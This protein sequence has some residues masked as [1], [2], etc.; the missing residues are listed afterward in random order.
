VIDEIN[1]HRALRRVTRPMHNFLPF[2]SARNLLVGIDLMHM[3]RKGRLMREGP[4]AISLADQF[5][6]S[7]EDI[8]AA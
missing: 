2:R 5:D 8:R 1:A 7:A 3:V 6:A 4:D